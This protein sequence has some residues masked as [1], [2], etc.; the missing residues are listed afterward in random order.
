Q[1][2]KDGVA[3]SGATSQS[4][5]GL[6]VNDAGVYKVRYTDPNG[7]TNTSADLAVTAMSSDLLYIYPN[8]NDGR[9]HVRFYNTAN[10]QATVRIFAA[11]GALVFT[12]VFT[13]SLP[14]SDL[15]IDLGGRVAAGIYIVEVRDSKGS[16]IG[17]KQVQIHIP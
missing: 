12:K 13:T 16:L 6:T 2:F 7:C 9:F 17:A 4:L 5:S 3:I 11:N 8:P 1:W 15:S 10:D 14:Y